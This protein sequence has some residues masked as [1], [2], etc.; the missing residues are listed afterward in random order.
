[1]FRGMNEIVYFLKNV[2]VSISMIVVYVLCV[3]C[4]IRFFIDPMYT[5]LNYISDNWSSTVLQDP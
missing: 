4:I 2:L 3:I 1:M 5:T